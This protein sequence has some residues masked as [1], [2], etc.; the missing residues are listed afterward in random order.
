MSTVNKREERD[1][2]RR[3]GSS[4]ITTITFYFSTWE[5]YHTGVLYL[6]YVNGPTEGLIISCIMLTISGMYGPQFWWQSAVRVVPALKDFVSP[7]TKLLEVILVLMF[8]L[9]LGT[10]VPVSIWRVIEARMKKKQSIAMALLQTLPFLSFVASM[11][12]WAAAPG[13]TIVRSH[14]VLYSVT[15]G[16]VFGRIATKII[17]AHLTK[18]EYPM[19]TVLQIPLLVAAI[20]ANAPSLFGT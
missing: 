19:F 6:G 7:E 17:L 15:V 20:L 11:Y 10:Q 16:I 18:L 5:T 9:S 3:L 2:V 12:L 14:V 13:S 1:R 8:V 4:L